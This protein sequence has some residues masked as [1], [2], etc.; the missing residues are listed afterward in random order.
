MRQRYVAVEICVTHRLGSTVHT[1][2]DGAICC[3]S[4][5]LQLFRMLSCSCQLKRSLMYAMFCCCCKAHSLQ[6]Y[7]GLMC[8]QDYAPLMLPYSCCIMS[9]CVAVTTVL[10][11]M[12]CGCCGE[13]HADMH[14]CPIM[15]VCLSVYLCLRLCVCFSF[16]L[17]VCVCV[18]VLVLQGVG[19]HYLG[20]LLICKTM[21]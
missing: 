8:C 14:S 15:T 9:S 13:L 4:Y 12:T 17:C 2:V 20:G 1:I 18:C 16:S 7:C 10:L 3:G 19:L 11:C 6:Y 5:R 21:F